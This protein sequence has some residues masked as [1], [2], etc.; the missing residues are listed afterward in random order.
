ME[1]KRDV[2]PLRFDIIQFGI[3]CEFAQAPL[4]CPGFGGV[5]EGGADALPP[6][7]GIHV[8]AFEISDRS[9]FAAV[10]HRPCAD[11]CKTCE[12]CVRSSRSDENNGIAA[13]TP[14][15]HFTSLRPLV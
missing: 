5:Q 8:P 15:D 3:R 9:G 11:L 14:C 7:I 13:C 2:S 6:H 10:R 12:P 1:T 4:A